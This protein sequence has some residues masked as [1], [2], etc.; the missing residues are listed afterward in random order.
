MINSILMHESY[1]PSPAREISE[2]LIFAASRV[3]KALRIGRVPRRQPAR[4][5]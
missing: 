1:E 4:L 5:Q 2:A 3:K